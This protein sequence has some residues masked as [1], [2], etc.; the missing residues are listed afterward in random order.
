MLD[1]NLIRNETEMVRENLKRRDKKENLKLLDEFLKKD[2]E[3]RKLKTKNQE[4]QHKRNVLSKKIGL[5]KKGKKDAS[6]QMKEV[7]DIPDKIKKNNQKTEKLRK[8]C[9]LLLMKIPNLIHDS[10]PDGKSEENNVVI[11]EFG[12]MKKDFK[13]KD[14]LEIGENLGIID[15]E[16][17]TKVSGN[18]FYYLKGDLVLLDFALIRF[19]MEHI[20]KKGY[21][22]I[23]TPFMMNRKPLEGV[24]NIEEFKDTIYKLEDEDLYL[25]GTAE[26]P[27]A[28]MYMDEVLKEDDLPLKLVGF[29][30]SFRKEIGSHGKYSRGLFRMHQFNKLEQMIICK[31]EDS[32]EYLEELQKNAEELYQ[33]L[34]LAYR[35]VNTCSGELGD[36]QAKMY[37][38]EILMGDGKYR[39]IGSNSNCTDYQ[40]R[41]LNIKHREKE[42]Q[43][44]KG[45]VHIVNN[46]AI[47]TSR[48]MIAILEQ[49]QQKDGSVA[50]PSV[51]QPYMNGKKVIKL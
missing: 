17:A 38:I 39:E 47:A 1:I 29:S 43:P 11:R 49:Y 19:A 46:T 5:L 7:A 23:E 27:L 44:P 36:K 16:R 34:G 3:W 26:A 2:G 51:L 28:A 22:L 24:V 30:T 20:M 45:Y 31:P 35:V 14:H 18:G 8:D 37:D 32:W 40:A 48:T 9:D 50:I 25:I 41:R 33:K 15:R 13:P 4:L 12:E 42:G 21:T 6:K 10:V